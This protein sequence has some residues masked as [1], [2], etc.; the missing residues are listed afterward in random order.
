MS[1]QPAVS[2]HVRTRSV[3]LSVCYFVLFLAVSCDR[4]S[5]NLLAPDGGGG[6]T[7]LADAP[8][9]GGSST[10]ALAGRAGL[11]NSPRDAGAPRGGASST[12]G[13]LSF[14]GNP[15]IGIGQGGSDEPCLSGELCTDGGLTCPPTVAVCKRC[16]TDADCGH[17][18]PPFC[19]LS[20]GRCV[21]CRVHENDCKAGETCDPAF[22]R[23]AKACVTKADC[24][25]SEPQCDTYRNVC[26]ECEDHTDCELLNPQGN[27]SCFAG[28]CV[29]CLDSSTCPLD[30]P[31]CQALHCVTKH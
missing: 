16:E 29:E 28:F 19:D 12:G 13:A 3:A 22:Q 7:G 5:F 23:C 18:A 31:E 2:A 10:L 1:G 27:D 24:D 11:G 30:R 6:L 26:V 20:A 25:A 21:E 9:S 17:D 14:G 15:Q 4:E 8:A